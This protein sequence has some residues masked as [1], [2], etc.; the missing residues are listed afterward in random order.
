MITRKVVIT[1]LQDG[2]YIGLPNPEND[3]NLL[4]ASDMLCGPM[5]H[6]DAQR[7]K[8]SLNNVLAYATMRVRTFTRGV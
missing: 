6:E 1:R 5:S 4:L 8:R 7:V 3:G 2:W